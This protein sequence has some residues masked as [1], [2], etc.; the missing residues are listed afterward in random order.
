MLSG[1]DF[2]ACGEVEVGLTEIAEPDAVAGADLVVNGQVNG[3]GLVD[4]PACCASVAGG[5]G[6][7]GA[8]RIG[9]GERR[10]CV[11]EGG[12]SCAGEMVWVPNS[13]SPAVTCGMTIPNL[14][15]D[16]AICSAG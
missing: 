14:I 2:G 16:A 7:G 1:D 5:G 12:G 10:K 4:A 9:C 13:S 8:R 11:G 6:P 3:D 15:S